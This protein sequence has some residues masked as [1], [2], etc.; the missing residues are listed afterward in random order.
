MNSL[1]YKKSLKKKNSKKVLIFYY[2][3]FFLFYKFFNFR[4][5]Y[6][7]YVTNFF[8]CNLI[9][10]LNKNRNFKN[11][12][13]LVS[14]N[15]KKGKFFSNFIHITKSFYCIYNLL[16]NLNS[17][18]DVTN[19]KY[20]KEFLY[21]FSKYRNY[22]NYLFILNW[23]LL[24]INPIFYIDCVVVPKKYKKKI[25]K[26]YLYKINYLNQSKRRTKSL[27]FINNYSNSLNYF[28][29]L[30][31]LTISYLDLIL[32]YKKSYIYFKKIN[33]YKKIFKV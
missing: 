23:I 19:Y 5:L 20:F 25:K 28:K 33:T 2:L 31:R 29:H 13:L 1:H 26:K 16:V 12:N 9:L 14:F 7:N 8:S 21:N 24:F 4:K 17:L 3:N 15:L 30:D 6:Y 11:L 22:N 18:L 32:N 27:R 10:N